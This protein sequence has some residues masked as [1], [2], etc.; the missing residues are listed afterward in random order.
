MNNW[1]ERIVVDKPF[2]WDFMSIWRGAGLCFL[3]AGLCSCLPGCVPVFQTLFLSSGLCSCLPDS[4]P[5]FR[6]VFLSSGLC[7]CLPGCVPVC[8]TLFLS[9]GLCS[10]LPGCVSC[11]VR[12]WNTPS[13][14]V[15]VPCATVGFLWLLLRQ[16]ELRR[17]SHHEAVMMGRETS[18]CPTPALSISVSMC[19]HVLLSTT[20]TPGGGRKAEGL[21]LVRSCRDPRGWDP[22]KWVLVKN[23]YSG[24]TSE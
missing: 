11:K 13:V 9:S 22:M 16:R 20:P 24:H 23:R 6:A 19:P 15:P 18:Y 21:V 5:I 8:R 7:S 3:S 14:L 1:V 17:T 2:T 10:Y 4:V 12:G